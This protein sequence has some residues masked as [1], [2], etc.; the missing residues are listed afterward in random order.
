MVSGC[1][2]LASGFEKDAA[3]MNGS[4]LF[5]GFEALLIWKHL[6]SKLLFVLGV[7]YLSKKVYFNC[8]IENKVTGLTDY[9]K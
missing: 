4:T 6:E 3:T 1:W 5:R 2:S 8:E 7:W 9:V